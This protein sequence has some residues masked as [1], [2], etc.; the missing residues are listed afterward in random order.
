MPLRSITPINDA[1]SSPDLKHGVPG[2]E[3]ARADKPEPPTSRVP[4]N[5]D[6]Q[7]SYLLYVGLIFGI[8]LVLRVLVVLMGPMFDIEQ[9]YTPQTELQLALAENLSSEQ[10]FGLEAQQPN[11]LPAAV[12]ALREHR[13]EL[14]TIEGTSLHPEHYESPGYP[15]ILSIFT[16]TGL[17][18]T[19]LLLAQC[20]L[21]A[22]AVPLVFKVGM[23][24][25]GRKLPAA[26]ACVIVALHPALLFSPATLAS[27]TIVTLLVLAGLWGIAHAERR[28][29]HT[30]AGSGLAVGVGALFSPMLV[31]LAPVLGAWMVVSERRLRS[32][33]LAV[34]L[35]IGAALPIGGWIY[36]NVQQGLDPSVSASLALDRLFGTVAAAEDPLA[37][38]Y[39]PQ[40]M[41]EIFSEFQVFAGVPDNSET[42]VIALVDS[43]GRERLNADRPGHVRAV[44][45]GA[46]KLGLDHSLDD[47][48]TRLGMDYVPAGYAATL[49]SEDVASVDTEIEEPV[50]EWVINGWVALNAALIAAMAVG[51]VILLYRRRFA[52]L[53]LML[54]VCGFYV[55]FSS[56]GASE[57]MRLPLIALQGL[58]I[59]GI[60]AP[61]AIRVKKAKKPS[62][63]KLRKL[64]RLEDERASAN[65]TGSPLATADSVRSKPGDN[66]SG[67]RTAD[68]DE[69]DQIALKDAVHPALAM[70]GAS[71]NEPEPAGAGMGRPSF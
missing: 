54:A 66:G 16:L 47:A 37:G 38:P 52:G 39:A 68:D 13:G 58:M 21:G 56:A 33:G 14:T 55:F 64:K 9:A 53:T 70:G 61:A 12:E 26:L 30:A 15:A 18:L 11:T 32:V 50:T 17:P 3:F 59:T 57:S 48:Y 7:E 63:R 51:A 49:L 20:L 28:E 35:M 34:A 65:T 6:D 4:T 5:P 42:G 29:F 2:V 19:W 69:A 62:V 31:W 60:L 43:Y 1:D 27:D 71:E 67:I 36:R 44:K 10:A 46:M 23:G 8:A 41:Q 40:T 24:V 25:L 45:L 22:L